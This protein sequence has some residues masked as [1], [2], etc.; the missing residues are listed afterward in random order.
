MIKVFVLGSRC[1]MSCRFCMS[2]EKDLEDY[3]VLANLLRMNPG[4]LAVFAGGEPLLYS[5][6]RDF[7]KIAKSRGLKTKI[8][9]NGILLSKIDFLDLIDI[10]NLPLDGS[11][12][13]HD[14]MRMDG[15][16][17]I[18]MD[19]FKLNK[20]FTITTVLTKKNIDCVDEL[21][22]I[23]NKL[24][25]RRRILNW[26]VF[27]FKAKGRGAKHRA[28]F[29]ITDEAFT[30]AVEFVKSESEVK[31]YAINDPDAMKTEVIRKL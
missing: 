12:D 19:A 4:D 29:E 20:R 31:V 15:H 13:V 26:K 11:K 2:V 24:A 21:V 18:V 27:K 30:N 16:F 22:D 3:V 10:I 8:H 1:N 5:N 14:G 7:L 28:E 17:D 6:L 23:I 9:T 25:K